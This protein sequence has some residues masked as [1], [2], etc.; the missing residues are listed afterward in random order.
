[1]KYGLVNAGAVQVWRERARGGVWERT[2]R[3]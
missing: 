2:A 3:T 1:L